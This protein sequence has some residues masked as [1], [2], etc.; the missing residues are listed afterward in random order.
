[1]LAYAAADKRLPHASWLQ[2]L[3]GRRVSEP[4]PGDLV[5][6]PFRHVAIYLGDGMVIGA[7]RSGTVSSISPLYGSPS[8][9]RM[10]N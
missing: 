1:M 9:Y 7:H 2:P 3:Y 8:F 10:V 4:R 6:W 5:K